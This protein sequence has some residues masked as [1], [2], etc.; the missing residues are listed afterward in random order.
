MPKDGLLNEPM[1]SAV[2]R[3]NVQLVGL[4]EVFRCVRSGGINVVGGC[5]SPQRELRMSFSEIQSNKFDWSN[6]PQLFSQNRTI[7]F[8]D[9]SSNFNQTLKIHS[10]GHK[11]LTPPQLPSRRSTALINFDL[12]G[13]YDLFGFSLYAHHKLWRSLR[14]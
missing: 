6:F 8:S 3:I 4:P 10:L 7:I 9:T 2:T 13:F 5:W 11:L 12:F 1:F 14:S